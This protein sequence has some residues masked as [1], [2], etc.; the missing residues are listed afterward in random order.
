MRALRD[1]NSGPSASEGDDIHSSPLNGRRRRWLGSGGNG[2]K[3]HDF[4]T[5][6]GG[7]ADRWSD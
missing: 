7:E 5:L 4:D 3:R 2:Q 1:S 6:L